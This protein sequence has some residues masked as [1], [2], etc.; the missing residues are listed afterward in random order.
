MIEQNQIEIGNFDI[1]EGIIDN[2]ESEV[3]D[4]C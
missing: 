4:E 3:R 1:V 2:I